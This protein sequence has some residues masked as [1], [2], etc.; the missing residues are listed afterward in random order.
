MHIP[1]DEESGAATAA[2]V[3]QPGPDRAVQICPAPAQ[4]RGGAPPA[5]GSLLL[6]L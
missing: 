6:E 3:R 4:A 5:S 2:V 1:G